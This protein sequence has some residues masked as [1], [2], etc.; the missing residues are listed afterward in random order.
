MGVTSSM[1]P[2]RNPALAKAR[3]AACAPAPGVLAPEPPGARTLMCMAVIPL[4]LATVAACDAAR[5]V[6]YAEDSRRSDLT[7]IP[8]EDRAIVSA[9]EM[10]VKWIIVL[11]YEL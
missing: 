10:S 6:A 7:C 5:M 1:R 9:P 2:T 11:L 3:M 8:P 4:S